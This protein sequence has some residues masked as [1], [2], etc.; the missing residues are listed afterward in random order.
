ML[1]QKK[2]AVYFVGQRGTP[3]KNR[4]LDSRLLSI[5]DLLD[6][7]KIS[8]KFLNNPDSSFSKDIRINI[9]RNPRLKMN[10]KRFYNFENSL[11]GYLKYF[12]HVISS[13]KSSKKTFYILYSQYFHHLL[14]FYLL[15]KIS[16]SKLV[17]Q[18]VEK[19]SR[20]V[21]LTQIQ[22]INHFLFEKTYNFFVDG[23]ITIS[24]L[25]SVEV[26]SKK[27]RFLQLGPIQ[28]INYTQGKKVDFGYKFML[29]CGSFT[30]KKSIDIVVNS[31][32]NSNAIKSHKLILIL[33][34]DINDIKNY[35][36]K[37]PSNI[38]VLNNILYSDLINYYFSADLLFM[39][40]ENNDQENYRFPNKL[41]EY[42]CNK[43]IILIN[44][45]NPSLRNIFNSDN[46]I[47]VNHYNHHSFSISINFFLTLSDNQKI[48]L[49]NQSFDLFLNHFDYRKYNDKLTY[50][51]NSI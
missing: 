46:S 40:L 43:G 4:A 39:P 8:Y 9:S 12:S 51:L 42:T 49:K 11:S 36:A 17:F 47:I 30:Y 6:Y 29:Y 44:I 34:G 20:F 13:R 2:M 1:N 50:L 37:L 3:Y 31:F 27:I 10:S 35:S 18:Y 22:K 7:C 32:L 38:I 15:A 21:E 24:D 45:F 28:N 14:C 19:R 16:N 33:S 23:C 5:S 26:K 25:L 48:M 41:S